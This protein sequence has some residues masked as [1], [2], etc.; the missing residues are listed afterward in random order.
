MC[1]ICLAHH[2][3]YFD[4]SKRSNFVPSFCEKF[5]PA[6]GMLTT[7]LQLADALVGLDVDGL[8]FPERAL[9][10]EWHDLR[11]V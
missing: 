2:S 9:A 1:F 11:T 5:Y 8:V 10:G 7:L 4:L 3:F 6:T